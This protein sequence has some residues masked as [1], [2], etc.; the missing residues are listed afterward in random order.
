MQDMS[1]SQII[2]MLK[3]DV[4]LKQIVFTIKTLYPECR[5]FTRKK[6]P[7]QMLGVYPLGLSEEECEKIGQLIDS[8]YTRDLAEEYPDYPFFI[9]SVYENELS[10]K[11]EVTTLF[12]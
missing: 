6:S 12:D 2:E 3:K 8:D 5:I 9:G 10:N 1:Y 11:I 4:Y 7:V